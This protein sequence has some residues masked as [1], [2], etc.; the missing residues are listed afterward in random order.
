VNLLPRPSHRPSPSHPP[1]SNLTPSPGIDPRSRIPTTAARPPDAQYQNSPRHTSIPPMSVRW[2]SVAVGDSPPNACCD[3][4]IAPSPPHAAGRLDNRATH[5][6]NAGR[7]TRTSRQVAKHATLGTR[8]RQHDR[9]YRSNNDRHGRYNDESPHSPTVDAKTSAR[10][11][12]HVSAKPIRPSRSPWCLSIV[13]SSNA[14]SMGQSN[15]SSPRQ[16]PRFALTQ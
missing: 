9:K 15:Q 2:S 10:R 7:K 4:A 6:L 3:I 13:A 8:A 12:L 5:I 16:R 11:A 1:P 14:I